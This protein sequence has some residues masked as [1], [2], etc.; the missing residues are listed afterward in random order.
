MNRS[1]KIIL[2]NLLTSILISYS[3]CHWATNNYQNKLKIH[4]LLV[5]GWRMQSAFNLF[6]SFYF[7][8]INKK[9]NEKNCIIIVVDH[10]CMKQNLII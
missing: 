2:H 10:I 9:R 4:K 1:A 7:N 5:V 3:V 6:I 8:T